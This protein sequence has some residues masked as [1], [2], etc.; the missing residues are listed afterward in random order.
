MTSTQF[1]QIPASSRIFKLHYVKCC[2][3]S[4]TYN[5]MTGQLTL[6]GQSFTA[7]SIVTVNFVA[8]LVTFLTPSS[9]NLIKD[10]GTYTYTIGNS[11]ATYIFTFSQTPL[12]GNP[13]TFT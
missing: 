8:C 1:N 7:T 11:A 9:S 2:L 4:A 10:L 12:C 3:Q 13:L 6:G 5:Q